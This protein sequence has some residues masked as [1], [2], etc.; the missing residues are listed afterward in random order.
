MLQVSSRYLWDALSNSFVY[1]WKNCLSILFQLT[2]LN[3]TEAWSES[4]TL[5]EGRCYPG[6]TFSDE[7]GLVISGGTQAAFQAKTIVEN[8][9]DGKNIA[10]SIP[11]LPEKVM[12]HCLVALEGGDLFTAGGIHY[13]LISRPMQFAVT[14][15]VIDSHRLCFLDLVVEE[16]V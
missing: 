8:T 3:S 1:L 11:Q 14:G 16:V 15:D 6:C 2:E 5:S 7:H 4:A 10:S 12:G 9:L 13:D